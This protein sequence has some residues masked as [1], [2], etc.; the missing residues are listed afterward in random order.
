M[1][2]DSLRKH[3]KEVARILQKFAEEITKMAGEMRKTKT[4]VGVLDEYSALKSAEKFY[5]KE[6]NAE[7]VI[8]SEEDDKKIDPK[9]RAH[10]AMPYRPAIYIE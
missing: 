10:F 5:K 9:N 3:G 7:V 2:E 1:V 8:F 6:L 4:A